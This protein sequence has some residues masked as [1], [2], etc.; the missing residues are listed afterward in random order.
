MLELI[1]WVLIAN[2]LLEELFDFLVMVYDA[3][4]FLYDYLGSAQTA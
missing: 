4:D 3:C 1:G 2:H